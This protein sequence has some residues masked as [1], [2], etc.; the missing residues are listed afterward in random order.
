MT[1]TTPE[2]KFQL[3]ADIS[4]ANGED[5]IGSATNADHFLFVEVHPPWPRDV[6]QAR[7]LPIDLADA[8]ESVKNADLKIKILAIQWDATY[9]LPGQT[10][11]MLFRRPAAYFARYQK[12]DYVVPDVLAPSLVRALF[13]D[14]DA[15]QTFEAYRQPTEHLREMFV[16]THGSRDTCCGQRGYPLY[17][18]LRKMDPPWAKMPIR[19]WRVSH[20]GGHKFATTM[21]DFPYGHYWGH[22]EI[23]VLPSLV[24]MSGSV[25]G[26]QPFY[27]GWSGAGHKF[28]QI[29][30]REIWQ[31]EG[32]GWLDYEKQGELLNLSE[33]G[34]WAE[35]RLDFRSPDGHRSGTY[36]ARVEVSSQIQTLAKSGF[37]ELS[38]VDQY[39]VT[40]LEQAEPLTTF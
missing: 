20:I 39:R 10:R 32:W 25:E 30:E 24:E 36:T 27:R 12:A 35:V 38:W 8:L 21:L 19:A 29:A 1:V 33:D 7:T 2:P 15:L 22:L 9:S 16:C 37:S 34:Q 3:C 11:V 14:I 23:P 4:K 13:G 28:V 31:R 40:R 26:L 5:P 6:W 17:D 18:I